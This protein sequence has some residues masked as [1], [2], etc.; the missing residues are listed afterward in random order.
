MFTLDD[1]WDITKHIRTLGDTTGDG[2]LDLIG[3]GDPGVYVSRNRGDNSFDLPQLVHLNMGYNVPCWRVDKNPRFAVDLRNKGYVDF[4]GFGYEGVYV[5]KNNGDGTYPAGTTLV[6][7]EFGFNQGWRTDKHIRYLVDLTGN[8][9]LDII[10]FGEND[11]ST[12][13]GKGD[14]TFG[15]R[16]ISFSN[17]SI[18]DGWDVKKHVRLLGDVTGNGLPDIVGFATQGVYVCI[19]KGDGTFELPNFLMNDFG[20]GR[21]TGAWRTEK[22]I[23]TLADMNGNG[24]LDIVGFGNEGV[25]VAFSN[26]DG[27]FQPAKIMIDTFGYDAGDWRVGKHP[28]FA[29]DMTGNGCA[30]IVAFGDQAVY[31]T[32]NDGKGSLGPY[33]TL[34]SEFAFRVENGT[35]S[36]QSAM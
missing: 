20:Y 34:T 10:G 28:R 33:E 32:Y 22:H 17:L 13:L 11:V 12:C 24:R 27:T 30:D 8:G 26:G 31:V 19:N 2:N 6:L 14:G 9:L 1:G 16:R 25:W 21:E 29:V 3:F 15:K 5:T 4:V 36:K 18:K 35:H 7:R 23:R